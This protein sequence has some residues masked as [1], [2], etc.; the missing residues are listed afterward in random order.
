VVIPAGEKPDNSEAIA[1]RE[2]RNAARAR[3]AE[4]AQDVQPE[5]NAD[6]RKAAVEAAIARA[7]ARKAGQQDVVVEPEQVDPRKLQ[8]KRLSPA[9][10]RVKPRSW[11]K[12]RS[13]TRRLIRAKLPLKQR[14]PGQ[15]TQSGTAGRTAP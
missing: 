10:K 2:A 15:S 6:P 1:A 8:W 12:P 11:S 4:K 3:Q 13:Q 5:V 7:K 9:P 14:L